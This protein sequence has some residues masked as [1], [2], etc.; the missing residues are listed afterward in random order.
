METKNETVVEELPTHLPK[1]WLDRLVS[2]SQE[3]KKA[4]AEIEAWRENLQKAVGALVQIERVVS[5]DYKL[6]SEDSI[7]PDGKIVRAI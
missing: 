7:E 2:A 3:V 1:L 6:T 5:E 4:Q